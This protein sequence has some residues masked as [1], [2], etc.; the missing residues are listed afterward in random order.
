MLSL[1]LPILTPSSTSSWPVHC[2]EEDIWQISDPALRCLVDGDHPHG[3]PSWNTRR[4]R[5]AGRCVLSA[6]P[7]ESFL[8]QQL[9]CHNDEAICHP[10]LLRCQSNLL[11]EAPSTDTARLRRQADPSLHPWS[12]FHQINKAYLL[13][14][15]QASHESYAL[16]HNGCKAL[17]RRLP[18]SRL[19]GRGE[20]N[21][22]NS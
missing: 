9:S 1:A 16:P 7:L 17:E 13:I 14:V 10:M 11:E 4:R 2:E 21:I 15:S 3:Q 5:Q 20:P 12:R 18:G 6:D 19:D 22:P 8:L